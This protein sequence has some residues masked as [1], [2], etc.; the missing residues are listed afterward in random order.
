MRLV[1]L[2]KNPDDTVQLRP[3]DFR[4]NDQLSPH[5]DDESSGP[6]DWFVKVMTEYY[7]KEHGE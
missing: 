1:I 3:F 6:P 4:E 7:K 2:P 5:I